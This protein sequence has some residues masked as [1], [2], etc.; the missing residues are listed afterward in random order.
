MKYPAILTVIVATV[1]SA[2][3]WFLSPYVTGYR[4]PWDAAGLY[5]VVSLVVGGLV[6]GLLA[7]KPVWA[8]YMGSVSGQL[9]YE[10]LFLQLDALFVVGLGFLLVYSLLFLFGAFLGSRVRIRLNGR[11]SAA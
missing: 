2:A 9:A 4:E 10:L 11:V 8:H 1:I 3:I 7:P 5:Y 6:S